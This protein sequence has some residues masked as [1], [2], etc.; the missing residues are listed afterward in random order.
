MYDAPP[1][2]QASQR[3]YA[4]W[5]EHMQDLG[6]EAPEELSWRESLVDVWRD[7]TLLIAQACGY[8]FATGLCGGAQLVATP[9]YEFRG[10]SGA[11]YASVLVAGAH[12]A[13]DQ[14]A[15]FRTQRVAINAWDS[16]SGFHAL[17]FHLFESVG[18]EPFVSES[19]VTGSHLASMESVASGSADLAAI[20]CVSWAHA[21]RDR[22]ALSARLCEI[23]FTAQAPGLPLI[24][25]ADRSAEEIEILRTSLRET[26]EDPRASSARQRL[27]LV[28]MQC[29]SDGHYKLI[30]ERS[31][32]ARRMP[33]PRS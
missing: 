12:R 23:E 4:L 27:G 16:Y 20:D 28:D 2:R 24:T 1:Q 18:A 3:F 25:G 21:Q 14:L 13:G 32:R 10:C 30:R 19:I 22:S 26:I 7:P 15:D 11:T 8:P 9:C 31:E 6:L 29:L 33:W 5:R 17:R